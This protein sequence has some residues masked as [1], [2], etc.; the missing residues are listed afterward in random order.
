MDTVLLKDSALFQS[1]SNSVEH[2]IRNC[3]VLVMAAICLNIDMTTAAE[4][5]LTTTLPAGVEYTDNLFMES[6]NEQSDT[7]LRIRPE[8][9]IINESEKN[10]LRLEAG[11]QLERYLAVKA[12]DRSDP[13]VGIYW[14]HFLKHSTF[15]VSIRDW[16]ASTR[17]S[18][19]E[20][21][22]RVNIFGVRRNV[23]IE[24]YWSGR[25]D[26][27]NSLSLRAVF[28]DVSYD[29]P[30]DASTYID[31]RDT[32][33]LAGWEHHIDSQKIFT[34][35]A[36]VFKYDG[37]GAG[38][39]YSSRELTAGVNYKVDDQLGFDISAG[40][41]LVLRETG[42]SLTT[43]HANASINAA[44]KNDSATLALSSE[45]RPSGGGELRQI[46]SFTLEYIKEWSSRLNLTLDAGIIRSSAAEGSGVNWNNYFSS[47]PGLNY[48]LLETLVLDGWYRYRESH[49]ELGGD[50]RI[51]NAFYIGLRYT[52][53]RIS[54][55]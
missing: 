12:A 32:R 44:R 29:V 7:I 8:I 27:K 33:V 39:D 49:Y 50:T 34:L 54:L 20:E 15:G 48:I 19:L 30:L 14:D 41:G 17:T 6:S 45:L 1:I 10:L 16:D 26:D 21:T 9:G 18:E 42:G 23:S 24:P 5:G 53:Q 47:Q 37:D 36:L 40:R 46:N 31:Y 4:W 43:W 35:D 52:P 25:L 3:L 28:L 2:S 55:N 38:L 51:E 13:F 11:I 22:G